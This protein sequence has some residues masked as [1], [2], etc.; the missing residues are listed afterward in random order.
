MDDAFDEQETRAGPSKL[1][2]EDDQEGHSDRNG[3]EEE[4]EHEGPVS[5]EDH[6]TAHDDGLGD[7]M[8]P[9]GFSGPSSKVVKP[10]TPEAL[11]KFQA[12]QDR[13]GVIYISR[14]PPGMRPPKVRH[15]MSMHGEVGRV[16]L[17]QE[18]P[19]RAYLRR[20][21]TSTKKPHFTEGW[22][23]FKDKRVARA[24][25]EMLNAQPIGGK[26]GSRWRDDVWTMKYLPR[27]KWNMLTEQIGAS[28]FQASLPHFSFFVPDRNWFELLS[29]YVI[30]IAHEAAVHRAKLRN[31]LAQSRAEQRAYLQN[32]E[33]ARV[34]EKRAKR[35]REAGVDV[36]TPFPG[37]RP[38]DQHTKSGES[39]ASGEGGKKRAMPPDKETEKEKGEK[40]RRK[41]VEKER[42]V[43]MGE[44][45][46]E[47]KLGTVLSSIF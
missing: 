24:V 4:E 10:L 3:E 14:I 12:E 21:H 23:E 18:D 7:G 46:R 34:L 27:F 6:E 5:D 37:P 9:S 29:R 22:V 13:A 42:R 33:T 1:Q 47:A 32:V 39:K 17:Q 25:A 41:E 35:K 38:K 16:Y 40:K 8:D 30:Y 31:E 28:L 44:R 36:Q 45:E 26:K 20:K 43:E 19:K 15:L 2:S 11:A